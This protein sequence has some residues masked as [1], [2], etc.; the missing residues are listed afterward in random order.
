MSNKEKA[1]I[2][3]ELEQGDANE[4]L[5]EK[6]K[7]SKKKNLS[8]MN[9]KVITLIILNIFIFPIIFFIYIFYDKTSKKFQY[10][11]NYKSNGN[12][13][14]KIIDLK[15]KH[16]INKPKNESETKKVSI[17]SIAQFP[18]GN[19]IF[20]DWISIYIYDINYNLIQK[21]NLHEI[22]DQRQYWKT[23][24]RIYKISIK[25]DNNFVIFSNDGLLKLFSKENGIFE[26]KQDFKDVEVV[27]AIFDSQGKIIACVRN[28]LIKI[29]K[30][31]EKGIYKSIKSIQQADALL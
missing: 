12:N 5:I 7:R 29:F 6:R 23:Q 31:D 24:K 8:I 22:V 10:E 26:L 19:I 3:E 17:E 4:D 27:D 25:D 9:S 30:Q 21:I 18:C 14:L 16:T 13:K 20:A 28:N 11:T 2:L 1:E 15:L